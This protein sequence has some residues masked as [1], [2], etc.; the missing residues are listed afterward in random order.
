MTLSLVSGAL[1]GLGIYALVRVFVRPRPGV[2]TMLAR[3]EGGQRSM[4]THTATPF[5]VARLG[6]KIL[7]R[8]G[9]KA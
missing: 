5:E 3:I 2:A 8:K 4:S 7:Y 1:L 9:G 6:G